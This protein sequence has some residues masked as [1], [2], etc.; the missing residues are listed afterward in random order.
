M[1]GADWARRGGFTRGE[2]LLGVGWLRGPMVG[3]TNV[4]MQILE[5]KYFE[6]Q[7]LINLNC[8]TFLAQNIVLFAWYVET[9]S[10]LY[11]KKVKVDI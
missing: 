6:F 5:G 4:D 2:G 8:H 9:K 11:K 10:Y 1:W 3:L 7:G